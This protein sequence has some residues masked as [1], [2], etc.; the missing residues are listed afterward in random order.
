[1]GAG[2]AVNDARQVTVIGAGI[3]GAST[4]LELQRAGFSVRLLDACGPGEGCS[5]GNAG[6]ISPGSIVP[7][8]TPGMLKKIPKWLIDPDGPLAVRWGYFPRALPWLV[9]WVR[10]GR[11]DR[12]KRNSAALVAMNSAPWEGYRELLTA[13]QFDDLMR[14]SGHLLAWRSAKPADGIA[15]EL[16]ERAGVA[17]SVLD[18][19][20]L[21]ELE[22]AIAP[23]YR[24][25]LL[26]PGNGYTVNPERLV[27]TI[28][29]N[30]VAAGGTF[31]R[32]R[33]LGFENGASGPR[34]LFTDCGT[35]TTGKVVLAAGA[36]SSE[37]AGQ[38]GIRVPLEAER[39]Y[40]IMLDAPN[41]KL[42]IPVLDAERRFM[43]TP[44]ERGLC[45][46]GTVEIAGVDAP[47][48]YSRSNK[49][50][51]QARRLLPGLPSEGTSSWMGMRPSMPDSLPVVDRH[52]EL[53]DVFFAF[54]HG[55]L[56]MTAAP[57]TARLVADLVTGRPPCIDPLPYRVGR[58]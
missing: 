2:H 18:E 25:A 52:P 41:V 9:R 20:Q 19:A 34:T 8:A 24:S 4:A 23:E 40:H 10:E 13:S 37:L 35:L 33:V 45:V 39:G 15:R 11:L 38:L 48:D 49:L 44:M 22:P 51:E 6:G 17:M 14:V 7:A 53:S 21:R 28:T 43:V 5:Y 29:A 12:L 1:M 16:R 27:K 46:A 58:F 31:V 50:F 57:R 54:G 56:G 36:W 32:R 47:A 30:L 55:H 3:V 26:L 42:K